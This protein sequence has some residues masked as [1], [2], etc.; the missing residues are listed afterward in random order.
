MWIDRAIASCEACELVAVASRDKG[1][2]EQAASEFGAR[3]SYADV[4]ELLG[5]KEVDAVVIC[6]PNF[7]H[8]PYV[9]AAL[10][11]GK[12]VLTEKPIADSYEEGSELVQEADR[13][14]LKL[15][16]SQNSRYLAAMAT[17]RDMICSGKV[18]RP[19]HMLYTLT[20]FY[21]GSSA[22]WKDCSR[23]LIANSGSHPLD[24]MPWLTDANPTRVY[25]TAHSNKPD[26]PGEDDF[27]V[28]LSLDNGTEAITY[29]T[30]SSTFTRKDMIIVCEKGTLFLDG[31]RKLVLDGEV[32]VE[33]SPDPFTL[34]MQ[35]FAHSILDSR[36]PA[37][38]GREVLTSL[39]LID[40]A[41]ESVEKGRAVDVAMKEGKWML[42]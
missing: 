42:K 23:F 33:G 22:W 25:A 35:E 39:A 40:A 30:L 17:A 3:R 29:T 38:S 8:F 28:H 12:H 41:Y 27:S 36:E 19:L 32:L 26:F 10:Q 31:L 2:R 4:V 9:M 13:C 24:F 16:S 1:R 37:N 6:A 21:D 34:Q 11:A 14:G 20:S 18:G 15:M 5:D 7:L